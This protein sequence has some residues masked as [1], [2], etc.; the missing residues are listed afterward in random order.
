MCDSMCVFLCFAQWPFVKDVIK[1]T[2]A[3]L[4]VP[5]SRRSGQ[6]CLKSAGYA[7]FVLVRNIPEGELLTF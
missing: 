4:V 5:F 1:S 6:R 3:A 2:Y 7:T